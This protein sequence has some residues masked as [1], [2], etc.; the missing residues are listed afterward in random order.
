MTRRPAA[1]RVGG[2]ALL[3]LQLSVLA[4]AEVPLPNLELT[5]LEAGVEE[6]LNTAREALESA[7]EGSEGGVRGRLYGHTGQ[8]F[9]AHHIF[10][11]AEACY[12]NAAELDPDELLWP[13]LLGYIYE[14]TS[15]FSEAKAKYERVLELDRTHPLAILRLARVLIDLGD[16]EL[17]GPLLQRVVEEPELAA[18]VQAA[19][20]KIA[21]S[22]EDHAAAA[23]HYEAA[24]EA[25]PQASQ[26]H[27]P[28]TVAY[29]RL[30]E[31]E[32]AREHAALGG[33]AKLVV[34]DAILNEVSSLSVSSQMFLTTGAQALKAERYDMA[35]KAFRGAIAANP[36]NKRAHLNLAAVLL[37]EGRLDAAEASAREALRLDP[38]FGFAFLNL[39]TIYQARDQLAEAIEFFGKALEQNPANLKANFRLAS[40]LMRTGDY[41]LAAKHF[42]TAVEISPSFVRAR[43][44]ES[45]A[46]IASRRYDDARRV[47][48]EAV[49]IQPDDPELSGA[50]ARL[51][52]TSE[53][54]SPAD[55]ERALAIAAKLDRDNP[56][57]VETLAMALAASGRFDSAISAQQALLQAA[58]GQAN[59]DLVQHLEYSLERYRQG[60]PNDR[61]WSVEASPGSIQEPTS[62]Q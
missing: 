15:R 57:N 54:C 53:A 28:L 10:A 5:G 51:L 12:Q 23:Q 47:L 50:L 33:P 17:A 40:V 34:P 36:E 21:T 32:K 31:I 35:E 13:Y 60:L 48:E 45:L 43:Y 22:V 61:P 30:G 29:R 37:H 44:L 8:I 3:L 46:W 39:G 27:Y 20:G 9:H 56:E 24:L 14:D 55:A 38:E 19:L 11:V 62:R 1:L 7:L 58:R 42:R 25:Q 26:L 18:P 2:L 41:E 59:A 16:I 4:S 6:R 49:E 52:A